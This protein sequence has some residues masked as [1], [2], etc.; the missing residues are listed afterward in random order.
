MSTKE[1]VLDVLRQMPEDVS[2]EDVAEEIAILAAIERGE[3]AAEEGRVIT[4][5]EAIKRSASW[6]SK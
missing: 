1:L 6:I 2:L 5:E 3:R 4:Q